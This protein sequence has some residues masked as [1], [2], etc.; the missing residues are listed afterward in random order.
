MHYVFIFIGAIY[1]VAVLA[2]FLACAAYMNNAG[3]AAD[4]AA[5]GPNQ[6]TPQET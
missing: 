4:K 5:H 3:A 1:A 6:M 2:Q